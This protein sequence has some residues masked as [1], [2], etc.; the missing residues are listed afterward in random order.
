M[1]DALLLQVLDISFLF[2]HVFGYQLI[3]NN[4]VLFC[5]VQVFGHQAA[6]Y[7]YDARCHLMSVVYI[8]HLPYHRK[9]EDSLR[10]PPCLCN[11]CQFLRLGVILHSKVWP[12]YKLK[13]VWVSFINWI[14]KQTFPCIL[15]KLSHEFAA[16]SA[17]QH[18]CQP[19]LQGAPL[20]F[21]KC[22]KLLFHFF[23]SMHGY[24]C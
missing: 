9:L 3:K 15:P 13:A 21:W 12:A 16:I 2:V 18:C 7:S 6:V 20:C 24:D 17:I 22:F 14:Y 5:F 23:A 4:F 8:H 1:L 19:S 10:R 11:V